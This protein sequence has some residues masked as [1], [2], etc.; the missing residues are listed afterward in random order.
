M[1]KTGVKTLGPCSQSVHIYLTSYINSEK[2]RLTMPN[3]IRFINLNKKVNNRTHAEHI[4]NEEKCV[5]KHKDTQ[6][7]TILHS[8]YAI[9]FVISYKV[10]QN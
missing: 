1:M 10:I 8:C 9:K 3:K 6:N 7:K 5:H 4:L 2:N